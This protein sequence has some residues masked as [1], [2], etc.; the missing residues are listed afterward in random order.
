MIR[1][2]NLA[3]KWIALKI[4]QIYESQICKNNS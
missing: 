4:N 3:V 1:A 2:S